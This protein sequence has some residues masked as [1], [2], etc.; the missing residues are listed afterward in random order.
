[1]KTFDLDENGNWLV[2][3]NPDEVMLVNLKHTL[4]TDPAQK[5]F[6]ANSGIPALE[7]IQ[8]GVSPDIFMAKTQQQFA[9][10]F[11]NLMITPVQGNKMS[12]KVDVILNSGASRSF[13]TI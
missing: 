5:P 6:N 4:Q 1:M 12:Y 13:Q 3:T 11:F 8:S 2:I 7:S 9:K 10:Y